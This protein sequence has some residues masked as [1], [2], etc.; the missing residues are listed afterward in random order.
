MVSHNI[1][2]FHSVKTTTNF[3]EVFIYLT[4]RTQIMLIAFSY[5]TVLNW[6]LYSKLWAKVFQPTWTQK[7]DTSVSPAISILQFSQALKNRFNMIT[8]SS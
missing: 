1:V 3:K 4:E 6:A 7:M 8:V 2:M 5:G